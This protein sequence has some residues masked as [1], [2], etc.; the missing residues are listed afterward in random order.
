MNFFSL[1]LPTKTYTKKYI[2]ANYGDPVFVDLNND[3]GFIILT[4]ITS[5]ITG[6]LARGYILDRCIDRYAE[7]L[8]FMIP[9]HY[10]SLAN[11]DLSQLQQILINRYFENKFEEELVKFVAGRDPGTL[12]RN[13]IEQFCKKYNIII[14]EDISSDA[15]IKM[16]WRHRK[17]NLEKSSRILS[18]GINPLTKQAIMAF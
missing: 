6:K 5:T 9:Y 13:S 1:Y 10:Y 2:L 4:S 16:E 7:K 18:D 11:H 17:K 14:E 8:Q 3:V 12:I 15:L